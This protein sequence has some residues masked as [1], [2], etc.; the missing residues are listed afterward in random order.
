MAVLYWQFRPSCPRPLAIAVD[1]GVNRG[2][3]LPLALQAVLN[4]FM[5][6]SQFLPRVE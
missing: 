4:F 5:N 6:I 3:D 1:I 2:V